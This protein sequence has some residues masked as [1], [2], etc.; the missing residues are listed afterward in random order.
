MGRVQWGCIHW[1]SI[2]HTTSVWN[3][4]AEPEACLL[5]AC[6]R[7]LAHALCSIARLLSSCGVGS[8]CTLWGEM[9]IWER[10]VRISSW[11]R[12][13]LEG[14]RGLLGM[15]SLLHCLAA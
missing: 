6:R 2:W 10:A 11:V 7:D 9:R 3:L 13:C 4:A 1:L 15:H 8:T 5:T 12:L 14:Q